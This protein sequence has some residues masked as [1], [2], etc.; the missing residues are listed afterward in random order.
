MKTLVF[1]RNLGAEAD[2]SIYLSSS[3][4]QRPEGI[5]QR[6]DEP[7]PLGGDLGSPT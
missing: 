3:A 4:S 7:G 2:A 1:I 5:T 6:L